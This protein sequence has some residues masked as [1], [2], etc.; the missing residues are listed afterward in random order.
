MTNRTRKWIRG[1]LEVII[2]GGTSALIAALVSLKT[3]DT[4]W[5]SKAFWT[6]VG[7]QFLGNGGLRFLQWWNNNPM[8]PEGDSTIIGKEGQ[9]LVPTPM[10]SL[11]PLAKVITLTP[12]P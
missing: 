9:P 6:S 2:H 10:I 3:G 4:A 12:K 1:G 11:N 8:P 7:A 5:F